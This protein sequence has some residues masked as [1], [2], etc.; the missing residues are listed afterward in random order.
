MHATKRREGGGVFDYTLSNTIGIVQRLRKKEIEEE[1]IDISLSFQTVPIL[2]LCMY[3]N[4]RTLLHYKGRDRGTD[5]T[6]CTNAESWNTY[7]QR[8][9]S[10]GQQS[11]GLQYKFGC[12]SYSTYTVKGGSKKSKLICGIRSKKI[13]SDNKTRNRSL[14]NVVVVVYVQLKTSFL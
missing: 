7:T 10:S 11:P 2:T 13:Q 8:R 5:V 6:R 4:Q 9:P 14:D 1:E 12:F 3:Y